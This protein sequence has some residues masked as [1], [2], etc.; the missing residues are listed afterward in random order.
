[1]SKEI[2][3]APIAEDAPAKLQPIPAVAVGDLKKAPVPTGPVT[4]KTVV[5]GNSTTDAMVT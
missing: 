2:A 1:M 3:S 5:N 4:I